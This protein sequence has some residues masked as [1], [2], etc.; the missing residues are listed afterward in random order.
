MTLP[1]ISY[2]DRTKGEPMGEEVRFDEEGGRT[3]FLDKLER[4]KVKTALNDDNW[5]EREGEFLKDVTWEP[6]DTNIYCTLV[7]KLPLRR[8][9]VLGVSRGGVCQPVCPSFGIYRGVR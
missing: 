1:P 8:W 3:K 5:Q 2:L 7:K 4:W 6:V 9:V